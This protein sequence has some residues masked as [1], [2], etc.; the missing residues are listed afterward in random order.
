MKTITDQNVTKEQLIRS[1]R[2]MF[3]LLSLVGLVVFAVGCVERRVVYVPAYQISP[4]YSYPAS[5]GPA[6]STNPPPANNAVVTQAPPPAQLEAVPA[7]PGP[8]Y[9]WT[10]GYWSWNGGWVWIGG[11]W[12]IRPHPSAVWVGGHWGRRGRGW[13]WMGGHWR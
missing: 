12:L 4:A 8:E 11:S 13:V 6:S 2:L 7:A 5:P 3:V 10:P 1:H 9:V